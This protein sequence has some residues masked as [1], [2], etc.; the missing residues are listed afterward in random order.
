MC[1]CNK[2]KIV[3]GG[4]VALFLAVSAAYVVKDNMLQRPIDSANDAT[5]VAIVGGSPIYL[6]DIQDFQKSNPQL[7]STPIELIYRDI[8]NGLVD[9]KALTIQA[10]KK[11]LDKSLEFK[12]NLKNAKDQILRAVY[13]KG[14]L[15]K[16]A[17][18]DKLKALYDDFVKE[19]PPED[20][21]Q[22]SHILVDSEA[23]AKAVIKKLKAGE[24]FAKLAADNS[25]DSNG[26][27]G[28][29]LG[30]FK[31]EAMVPEFANAVFAMKVGEI[32]DK[33]VKTMFGWHIV[34]VTDR[35]VSEPPAFEQ[36]K[37]LLK[38]R[39]S[40]KLYP[41]IIEKAKADAGVVMMPMAYKNSLV[42]LVSE[43]EDE[44]VAGEGEVVVEEEGV[45][46]DEDSDDADESDASD[47]GTSAAAKSGS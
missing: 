21:V 25:I 37:G 12:R 43:A 42:D 15:D 24:D 5:V 8:L 27:N 1:C 39:L 17:T 30:Y 9:G 46:V 28:G 2:G 6:A 4:V 34:K 20:E 29:E 10:E 11:S 40:E 41:E 3:F 44:D 32:S 26:R 14:E 22:A 33:P 38:M 45:E 7:E 13:V 31:K 18:D 36:V 23:K 47:T 19:N 16:L 35:R